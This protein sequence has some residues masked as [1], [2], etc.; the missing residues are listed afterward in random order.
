MTTVKIAKLKSHLSAYLR[1]VQKGEQL[2]VTDRETPIAKVIPY[3]ATSERLQIMSAKEKPQIF[4]NLKVP[5]TSKPMDSL[6]TLLEDRKDDL[7]D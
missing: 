7:E 4:K 3:A 1:Q 5:R 6:K 2:I